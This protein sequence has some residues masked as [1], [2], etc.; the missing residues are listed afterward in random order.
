MRFFLGGEVRAVEIFRASS[1]AVASATVGL[2]DDH[3]TIPGALAYAVAA[4]GQLAPLLVREAPDAPASL[5]SLFLCSREAHAVLGIGR[6]WVGLGE[7]ASQ[8][9]LT[10][11]AAKCGF[12]R[13]LD[14]RR[15]P[16]LESVGCLNS[17]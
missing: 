13:H 15:K 8:E 10:N 7:A 5:P 1:P 17:D 9:L 6:V 16:P 12:C 4:V 3:P 2:E 14:D 11:L